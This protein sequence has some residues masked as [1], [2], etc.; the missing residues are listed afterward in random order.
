MHSGQYGRISELGARHASRNLSVSLF[1]LSVKAHLVT[2]CRGSVVSEDDLLMILSK[3]KIYNNN[4]EKESSP[5]WVCVESRWR[6]S[7]SQL[8]DS[9]N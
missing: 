6:S 9:V 7:I 5:W 4:G 2:A 8:T 3:I 1:N